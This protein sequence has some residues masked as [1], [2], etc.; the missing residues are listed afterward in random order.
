M[1]LGPGNGTALAPPSKTRRVREY[2]RAEPEGGLAE[3]SSPGAQN[4]PSWPQRAGLRDRPHGETTMAW[5][6]GCADE[7]CLARSRSGAKLCRRHFGSEVAL[8]PAARR[9]KVRLQTIFR[10]EHRTE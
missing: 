3:R 6:T 2:R 10:I 8:G 7:T 1:S 4:E 9:R 5:V